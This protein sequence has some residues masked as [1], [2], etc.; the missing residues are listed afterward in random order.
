[1]AE[2][3]K[4]RSTSSS[5]STPP[6]STPPPGTETPEQAER[7]AERER[8]D[9]EREAERRLPSTPTETPDPAIHDPESDEHKAA[10]EAVAEKV[11][12]EGQEEAD[13]IKAQRMVLGYAPPL[14][15]GDPR[16]REVKEAEAMEAM[17][18]KPSDPLSSEA[19]GDLGG[20]GGSVD[21]PSDED[22]S[23]RI[24]AT[25]GAPGLTGAMATTSTPISVERSVIINGVA[26]I[27]P[28]GS[29]VKVPEAVGEVLENA[30]N[31]YRTEQMRGVSG[32]PT[33]DLRDQQD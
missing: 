26:F 17:G 9:R 11:F 22:L 2:T 1:M 19:L 10:V 6:P 12:G 7:R 33:V 28:T 31:P 21:V 13:K 4:P 14:D 8:A 5:P 29:D 27:V 15:P 3:P 24:D 18:Y 32:L 23:D 30:A 20:G 25:R 16:P